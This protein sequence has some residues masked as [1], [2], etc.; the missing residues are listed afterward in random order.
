MGYSSSCQQVVQDWYKISLT[1]QGTVTYSY[2]APTLGKVQKNINLK[3]TYMGGGYDQ[4]F[5]PEFTRQ[6]A[7]SN[8]SISGQITQKNPKPE[9]FGHFG[10]TSPYFSGEFPPVTG[11]DEICPRT[12]PEFF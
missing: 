10:D 8:S 1:L 11:R 2:I 7:R 9:C 6:L 3:A 5:P 4:L 12:Q